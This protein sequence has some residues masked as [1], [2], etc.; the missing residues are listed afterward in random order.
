MTNKFQTPM[1]KTKAELDI[2]IWIYLE[3]NSIIPS[4]PVG[5]G[6]GEGETQPVHP[7]L[8]PP[9]SRGRIIVGNFHRS[10]VIN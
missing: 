9:P 6:G 7:H 1:N 10:W 2:W 4:P 3:N 5:E 8:D